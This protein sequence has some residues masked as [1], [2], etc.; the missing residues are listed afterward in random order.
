MK[1]RMTIAAIAAAGLA[2]LAVPASA[3]DT[4]GDASFATSLNGAN[5]ASAAGDSDGSAVAFLGVQGD[6]VSFAIQFNDIA[7]PTRGDLHQGVKGSNGDV[8]VSFFTTRLLT[9]RNSV[10]GT[11]RVT[12][13]KLLANLRTNP[14]DFYIDLHNNQFPAGAVRGQVHKL[15]STIDMRRALEQNFKASVIK[16]VQIYACTQQADGTFAFTQ[17]NV[18]ASLQRGI[19]HFFANPGP[20]GPPEWRSDDGSAVTGRVIS[21]T[22]NGNGNIA[23]L[24]LA[25]TQVGQPD[26]LLAQTNEILRLNTVGGVAPAG[27]CDAGTQPK[28]EVPYQAD[29]LFVHAAS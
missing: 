25:A 9:G 27:P 16:G 13:Q 18:Q 6:Q 4:V 29:Y 7:I 28:A 2:S 24:D 12:D 19:S 8:K 5:V 15:T 26:G 10:S 22:P 20:S 3:D 17:D 11:V 23:E 21:R 1:R 14:G